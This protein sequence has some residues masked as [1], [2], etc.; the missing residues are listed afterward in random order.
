[1]TDGVA[2]RLRI[3]A[4]NNPWYLLATLYGQPT[5]EDAELQV[6]NRTGWNRCMARALTEE[7]RAA[8]LARKGYP[9]EELVPF[10]DEELHAIE[11]AFAERRQQAACTA[12]ATI[13]DPLESEA[14]DFSDVD[15]D[16]HFLV[17]GFVF[18]AHAD[19]T[20]AT[21]NKWAS[22]RR[23]TFFGRAD[24][25]GATFSKWAN[26]P[27]ATFSERAVFQGATFS[28][29]ADFQGA[30]FSKWADFQDA[31]FSGWADFQGATFRGEISFVNAE[32]KGETS[33]AAAEFKAEPPRFF[34]AKPHEGTVW[35]RVHWPDRPKD[36]ERAERFIDAYERL[37]LEMDRLKK[38]EDELN[39][40][41]REMQCRR[42]LQGVS[43]LPAALYGLLCNYGRSYV[44]P[45]WG[46]L[47]TA[48]VGIPLFWLHLRLGHFGKAVCLSLANTFG[49]FGFRKDFIDPKLIESLPGTLQV[50]SAVQTI[51]GT[52]LLFLFGLALRNRFRMK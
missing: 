37:K 14:I 7:A 29:R 17:D 15:F 24:F 10:S 23:A 3:K 11:G 5:F 35:H 47:I 28:E 43:G 45:L 9:A 46:L 1:M 2:Q 4:E 51:A 27:G 25:P 21:F 19:F 40:F 32:L 49:A 48:A 8:L 36:S 18:P 16:N 33:F 20:R 42:V 30:T 44:R 12:H 52:T 6:R 13:P 39:F 50:F 31:T 22:F 34:N 38:H 26:F 41:A